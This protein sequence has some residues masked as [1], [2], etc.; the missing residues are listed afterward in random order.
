M[1][2]RVITI[3]LSTENFLQSPFDLFAF[4]HLSLSSCD[5]LDGAHSG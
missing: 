1:G 4:C 5:H 3:E 2:K